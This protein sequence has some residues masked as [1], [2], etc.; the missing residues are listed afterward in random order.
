[1]DLAQY[2]QPLRKWWWLLVISAAF[3]AAS[4]YYVVSQQPP[5]YQATATLLTGSAFGDPN[6]TDSELYLGE[7]L[8]RTYANLGLRR[9]IQE[10]TMAAIGQNW[11]PDYI[12][13]PVPNSQLLEILVTSTDPLLAQRVANELA[14]QLILQTPRS[15]GSE[16]QE[17]QAFIDNQLTVLQERIQETEEEIVKQQQE[18]EEAFSAREISDLQ[19]EIGGLQSKLTSLQENYGLLLSSS[20][21]GAINT[22]TLIEPAP[23]PQQPIGPG[24]MQT[25]LITVM[26]A[27]TLSAGTAYLLVYLDDTINTTDDVSRASDLRHL[28]NI[29][30]IKVKEGSPRVVSLEESLEPAAVDAFRALRT[31]VEFRLKDKANPVILVTSSMPED[32]KSTV[33]ANLA[34]VFSQS[35]STVLLI[36]ADMRRP[37]L[38]RLFRLSDLNGFA[39]FMLKYKSNSTALYMED[40]LENCIEQS[41]QTNLWIMHSGASNHMDAQ[42]PGMA[43]LDE[44]LSAASNRFDYIIVDSAPLLATSDSLSISAKVDGVILL[45][46]AGKTR[47]KEL[48]NV[49]TQLT[50][51]EANVLGVVL[52]RVKKDNTAYAYKYYGPYA[53]K[54]KTEQVKHQPAKTAGEIR[55]TI[56]EGKPL[57]QVTELPQT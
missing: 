27:L 28:P 20:D 1:M 22:L 53:K 7:R 17:R 35:G 55:P 32:G 33:A 18:L 16:D 49:T 54:S 57:E 5:V 12:V 26:V 3:A 50:M 8:A 25:V 37:A 23:I 9:P 38:N 45:A 29:P 30:F 10:K 44:V 24:R 43:I 46:R 34:V 36:D 56:S 14:N 15:P 41:A 6:P 52:N 42:M 31:I 51:V 11:L 48:E 21:G 39:K 2:F 4:S 47:R 19:A 13:R 40:L